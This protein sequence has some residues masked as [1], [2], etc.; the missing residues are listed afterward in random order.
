VTGLEFAVL[1]VQPDSYAATPNLLFRLRITE[2][3]GEPV[4]AIALRCQIR[5][6]P[7]R[8]RYAGPEQDRLVELFGTAE[9]WGETVKPFLWTQTTA[10]VPGFTGGTEIDL[11]VACT[12]DFEVAASKY[13]HAL[14]DG[15]IPLILLFSGTVF[16]RGLTGFGVAQ[17]PWHLE[18]D[19]R[20][21]ALV[22]RQLM[23]CY[24]PNS[25]WIR[26]DRET[27][28]RLIHYK[29]ARALPTWEQ[30]FESLLAAAPPKGETV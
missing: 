8:R 10:M 1:D 3:T 21:P 30:T 18:A 13:L 29:T 5:I 11:P 28:D 26:T 17:I 16:T 25:G 7:Q 4:H 14:R 12:Y 2:A 15:E 6:E 22:W 19:Y 9:R 24:F 20:L 23:D 27:I